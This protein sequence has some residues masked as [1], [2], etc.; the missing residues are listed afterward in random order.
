MSL[1][2]QTSTLTTTLRT[3]STRL[4][5][6]TLN[7]DT[8]V[9]STQSIVQTLTSTWNNTVTSTAMSTLTQKSIGP[10]AISVSSVTLYSGVAATNATQPTSSLQIS[11]DNLNAPTYI[12][13]IILEAQ[14]G[15]L[16]TAWDSS[17]SPSSPGNLID[18]SSSHPGINALSGSSISFF[19][20]YPEAQ[21]PVSIASGT[22]CQYTVLFASGSLI[23]GNITA[24]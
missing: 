7:N 23:E 9:T 15:L 6:V 12:T 5:T 21:S 14:G 10:S 19:T 13:S 20:F 8:T 11:F 24:Q 4:A 2:T 3:T 16:I 22:S 1:V 18:F 17:L